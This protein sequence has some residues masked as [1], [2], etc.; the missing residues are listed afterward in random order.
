MTVSEEG[1]DGA[2]VTK[3]T[4]KTRSPVW[5]VLDSDLRQ[6]FHQSTDDTFWETAVSTSGLFDMHVT[7]RWLRS[8]WHFYRK[9]T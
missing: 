7:A 1:E 6:I 3:I 4:Q 5:S 8:V 9:S 2:R